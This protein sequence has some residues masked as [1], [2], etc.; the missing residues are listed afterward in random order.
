LGS[1]EGATAVLSSDGTR[2]AYVSQHKL[3]TRRLD[4]PT[5]VELAGTDGAYA[6]FFSPDGERLAFFTP[7]KLKNVA[8]AGGAVVELADA[9][10]ISVGGSTW[11][12]DGSIIAALGGRTGLRRI[13]HA[14][15]MSTRVTE[16]EGESSHRWPQMLPG[17][18]VVVFTSAPSPTTLDGSTIEA[19][20]LAD[21]RRKALVRGTFGR[22]LPASTG[23]GH[24]L[25]VS[26]GVMF[27]QPFDPDSLELHGT[28]SPVLDDVA[29][30]RTTA[31]WWRRT[32]RREIRSSRTSRAYGP[33]RHSRTSAGSAAGTST[34]RRT[35]NE[36][37]CWYR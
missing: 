27:A 29:S 2:I 25:Y 17:S 13:P 8:V 30:G 37:P 23:P 16:R 14:E 33:I 18:R 22:Y 7:G 9:G 36:S 5:A 11:G 31:S 4:Q 20:S 15:G 1:R 3:F 26:K 6:P 12:D 21:T 35:A 34:W 32:P 28:P 19:I 10:R 24:L